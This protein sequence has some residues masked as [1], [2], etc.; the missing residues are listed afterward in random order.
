MKNRTGT[1]MCCLW[2]ICNFH[3]I[4]LIFYQNY[5]YLNLLKYQFN[6]KKIV[7]FVLLAYFWV[8]PIF[9][10]SYFKTITLFL[11]P[12]S[13]KNPIKFRQKI[14]EWFFGNFISQKILALEIWFV[15]QMKI[16]VTFDWLNQLVLRFDLENW[17][18]FSTKKII[19]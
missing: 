15:L 13:G 3:T 10:C 4:K 18:K 6:W 1:K 17:V 19:L 8:S 16:K 2:K 11:L 14:S 5:L 7:Y 12:L 9:H